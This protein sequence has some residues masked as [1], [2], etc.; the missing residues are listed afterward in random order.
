MLIIDDAGMEEKITG[1]NFKPGNDD[2]AVSKS[3]TDK[4]NILII[5]ELLYVWHVS[6][7][8]YLRKWRMSLLQPC[9]LYAYIIY[10]LLRIYQ[11]TDKEL[12]V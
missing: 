9:L 7:A 5:Y 1:G 11:L 8:S 12:V 10:A 3:D 2:N 6:K 4:K